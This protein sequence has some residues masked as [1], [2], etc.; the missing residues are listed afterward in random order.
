MLREVDPNHD[1]FVGPI[2]MWM[3]FHPEAYKTGRVEYLEDELNELMN[4]KNKNE[5][6]AKKEFDKRVIE[7]KHKAIEDNKKKAINSGNLLSQTLDN[8]NNLV[9]VKTINTFDNN[10]NDNADVSDIHKELFEDE[11]ILTKKNKTLINI[12]EEEPELKVDE[13]K[14]D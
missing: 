8:D 14:K 6:Y 3:P 11:N 13:D 2:G 5:E 9:S 4:E 1:V 10:L 7:S 12:A